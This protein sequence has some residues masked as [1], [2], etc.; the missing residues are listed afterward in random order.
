DAAGSQA[1]LRDRVSVLLDRLAPVAVDLGCVDELEQVAR[2]AE[3]GTSADRQL[4][5]YSRLGGTRDALRAVVDSE[6]DAFERSVR[7]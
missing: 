6:A 5:T 4:E 3:T 1:R 2:I 7:G